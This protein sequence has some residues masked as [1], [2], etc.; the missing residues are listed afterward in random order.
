MYVIG[1]FINGITINPMEYVQGDDG[2]E[3]VFF[4]KESALAHVKYESEEE[5][6]KDGIHLRR[7]EECC[8]CKASLIEPFPEENETGIYCDECKPEEK[9]PMFENSL[10]DNV[11]DAIREK[12]LTS[13]Y[14]V[15]EDEDK[16]NEDSCSIADAV[17]DALGITENEQDYI[18]EKAEVEVFKSKDE[19]NKD[20]MKWL[21]RIETGDK[22]PQIVDITYSKKKGVSVAIHPLLRGK[23]EVRVVE[24]LSPRS[25]SKFNIDV[26]D[27][28]EK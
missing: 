10:R 22:L 27:G 28:T 4:T 11:K 13:C 12:L 19:K 18:A 1:R 26:Y 23:V 6:E 25:V 5:A 16:A 2:S 8:K 3:M 9:R 14:A 15:S 21:D 20:E 7:Y 17:F 24:R